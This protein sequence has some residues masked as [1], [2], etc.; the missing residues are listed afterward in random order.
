MREVN[1]RVNNS[2]QIVAAMLVLHGS[3]STNEG[4]QHE[5]RQAGSR[6]AAVA[7]AHRRLYSGDQIDALDLGAYLRDV[8]K[9]IGETLPGCE[10]AVSAEPGI[11][12]RIDSA[13]PAVL[14]VNELITNAAKYAYPG[15]QCRVWV[16][17]SRDPEG[18][19]VISVRDEG[20]GLPPSFNERKS[21]GLGMRLVNAF[22]QQLRGELRV[23]RRDPGTEFVLRFPSRA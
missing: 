18:A 13:V 6:I 15:R 2:L 4:V 9:D 10:I 8:C 23:R 1:H 14:A 12:I 19:V 5:L 17:L 16:T 22:A 21:T 3:G 7:R 20:A 11:V